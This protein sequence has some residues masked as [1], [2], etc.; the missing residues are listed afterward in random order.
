MI[1]FNRTRIALHLVCIKYKNQITALI[2]LIIAEYVH[3]LSSSTVQIV[4]RQLIKLRPRKYNIISVN[5]QIFFH[6]LLLR[7]MAF[8]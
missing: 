7:Y 6:W 2:S 1:F 5:E 4:L 8:F 3:K